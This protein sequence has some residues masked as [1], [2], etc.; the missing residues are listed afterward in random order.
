MSKFLKSDY[1][2][3]SIIAVIFISFAYIFWGTQGLFSIDT[4]REFYIPQQMLNGEVL[5]KDIF[6]I[7]GALSY[8]INA[9]LF[10]IFGTKITT[11]YSTGLFNS[12]IIIIILYFLLKNICQNHRFVL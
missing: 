11:L 8:Q 6:N 9:I 2:V 5:Y 1:F 4:G 7:Y 10:A 12:F 3:I